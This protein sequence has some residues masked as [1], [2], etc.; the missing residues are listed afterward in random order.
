MRARGREMSIIVD[1]TNIGD[2]WSLGDL[3]VN[4]RTD[5]LR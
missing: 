3:R 1:N 2:T 5:G 4:S